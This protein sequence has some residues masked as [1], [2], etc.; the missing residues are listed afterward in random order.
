MFGLRIDTDRDDKAGAF[1]DLTATQK[2]NLENKI[3]GLLL[4]E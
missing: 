4:A 3:P 2:A 1:N